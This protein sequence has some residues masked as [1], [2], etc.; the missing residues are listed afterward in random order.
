MINALTN[1]FRLGNNS[2]IILMVLKQTEFLMTLKANT[3]WIPTLLTTDLRV[4]CILCG[5]ESC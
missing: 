1:V 5:D 4:V 3:D 2:S